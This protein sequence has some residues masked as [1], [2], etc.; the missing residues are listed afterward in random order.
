M[1]G[2]ATV[3]L[4]RIMLLGVTREEFGDRVVMGVMVGN[5]EVRLG[6]GTGAKLFEMEPTSGE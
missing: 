5:N 1:N 2:S 4:P 3:W 6:Y